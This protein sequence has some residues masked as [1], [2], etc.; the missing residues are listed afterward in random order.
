[1]R[2]DSKKLLDG[3][4]VLIGSDY[5]QHV[6]ESQITVFLG[7]YNG[8]QYLDLLIDQILLQELNEFPLLIVDNSSTDGS[9]EQILQ[10]PLELRRRTKLVRN[11]INVGGIGTLVLNLVEVETPWLVSL[12]QDDIYLPNHLKVLK[13]SI[14]TAS[15]DEVVVFTDMGT[16]DVQGRRVETVIRQSWVADLSTPEASFIAN[17]VQ[18]SVSYPSAAFRTSALSR[19]DIPWHSTSFPDTEITLLQSPI[20]KF[21]FITEQTMLYR[22]NP[23]ST[24]RDL[25]SRERLLGPL[26]SLARVMGSESFYLLCSE[27]AEENRQKFSK[28]VLAGIQMR[29]GE[30]PLCEIVKL[31]AAETMA[32]AWDYTEKNSREQILQTYKL[33]EDGRTTKLLEELGA[34]YAEGNSTPTARYS[35]PFSGAQIELEKLLSAATPPSNSQAS[36]AQR[37]LLTLIGRLFPLPIRRKVVSFVVRIYARLNPTS[38][39]NLSWK[40]K[41]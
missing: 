26:A 8:A 39:W 7:V 27:V 11:P 12:H 41:R 37:L 31:I 3:R 13:E 4:E 38:P 20:G 35:K 2:V 17:L 9:W 29:L 14:E 25:D 24:S 5:A 22:V 15:E 10:W 21:K 36:A 19:V 23:D 34:F 33:A 40:P 32:L 6:A 18:Q 16:V 1:M 30:S 28:A